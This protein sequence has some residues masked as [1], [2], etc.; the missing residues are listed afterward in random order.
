MAVLFTNNATTTLSSGITNVA[1][2]IPVSTGT[3]TLFPSPTG[4]DIFYA[5][6]IDASN[7]IEIVKVTAR[8]TD[9]MT[10][11]RAQEGTTAK[12]YLSGDKFELR[13]TAAGFTSKADKTGGAFTG[14]VLLPA[15]T[16]AAAS[17]NVTTGAAP[18]SPVSGDVWYV[19]PSYFYYS[20]AATR[21]LATLD[22][23]ESLSNKTFVSP[24]S[25]NPTFTG[26]P[27]AP[28]A[29]G[30]TNTTQLATTAYVFVNFAVLASPTFTG[31][32]AA[33]TA[34]LGTS[35]T[36]LATTAF[37]A[38]AVSAVSSPSA[39]FS[40]ADADSNTHKVA[41]GATQTLTLGT[42]TAGVGFTVRFTTAWSL[43]IAGGLSKNGV[44]PAGITTGSVAANSL[45]TFFH[46]GSG[47]WIAT[48]SGLT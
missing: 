45:I 8:A 7:N 6:L 19:S 41:S 24:T 5:T 47:V 2:T 28:T 25:S 9:S 36:Q 16:T 21:Q 13:P 10:V 40:A 15:S 23:V 4:T 37:V 35:T 33:P 46:E 39:S 44:A 34:A 17:L 3:G 14:Q 1:T 38:G 29:A 22:G 11:V 43:T 20:G 27:V 32:P 42:I 18:T 12:A 30:G 31:T 26:V 48:G